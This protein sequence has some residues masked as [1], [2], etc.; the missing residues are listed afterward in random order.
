MTTKP[1][2]NVDTV[3]HLDVGD[4]FTLSKEIACYTSSAMPVSVHIQEMKA[5]LNH[6]CAMTV[7]RVKRM[8]D[9]REFKV[10]TTASFNSESRLFV[11]AIIE[12]TV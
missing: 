2:S 4:A 6:Q 9:S 7:H 5:S 12:R 1:G 11:M 10:T 3:A 8:H